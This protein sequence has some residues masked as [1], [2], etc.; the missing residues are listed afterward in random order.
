MYLFMDLPLCSRPPLNTIIMAL[1]GKTKD[2]APKPTTNLWVTNVI[3]R[4]IMTASAVL[5]NDNVV[6]K[7]P[8]MTV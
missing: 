2:N 3:S 4:S 7:P 5:N 6:P 8:C 1:N